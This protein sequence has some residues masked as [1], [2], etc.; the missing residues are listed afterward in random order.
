M[1]NLTVVAKITA[2]AGKQEVVYSDLKNLIEPT[3]TK[4]AGCI[5]YVLYRDQN[6]PAVFFFLEIWESKEL[7]DR[8]LDSEHFKVFA[9]ATADT[10]AKSEVHLLTKAG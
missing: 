6:D 3:C 8:H 2:K 1:T 5:S 4:D 10:V 9:K 7:L